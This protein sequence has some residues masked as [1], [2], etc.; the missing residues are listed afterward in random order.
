MSKVT[1]QKHPHG[2]GTN[3]AVISRY[4]AS[5]QH[6]QDVVKSDSD[7]NIPTCTAQSRQTVS[8]RVESNQNNVDRQT[9][10]DS[11]RLHGMS[12]HASDRQTDMEEDKTDMRVNYRTHIQRALSSLTS[13]VGGYMHAGVVSLKE[14]SSLPAICVQGIGRLS[15]PLNAGQEG[16]YACVCVYCLFLYICWF[17]R[18]MCARHWPPVP[19]FDQMTR[20]C[21]CMYACVCVCACRARTRIHT[22]NADTAI[23]SL[24]ALKL[25]N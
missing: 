2:T 24:V 20:R 12:D 5:S 1:P 21:V 25:V 9:D 17:T 22:H 15:L 13:N 19:A 3:S 16:V 23:L 4:N 7:S 6:K 11:D 10:T 18:D 8:E 14:V